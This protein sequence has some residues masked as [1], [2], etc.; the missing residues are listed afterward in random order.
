MPKVSICIPAYENPEGIKRLLRSIAGQ[1]YTDCEVILSDDSA[2]DAVERAVTEMAGAFHVSFAGGRIPLRYLRNAA[3]HGAVA[4]WNA[5]V[6][7]AQGEYVKLMHHDDW[8]TGADSLGALAALLDAH[9]DCDLAFCGTRQVPLGQQEQRER[10]AAE[11]GVSGQKQERK[12]QK[13]AANSASGPEQAAP[14]N[15]AEQLTAAGTAR[16]TGEE[17]L[18]LIRRDWRNLF[19]GNTIGAPS[20]VIVRKNLL[21][22]CAIRYDERLTWL[23]DGDYYMQILR[24]NPRFASTREPLVSIGLS[25]SQLTER[26]IDDEALVRGETVYLYRKYRLHDA[27]DPKRRAGSNQT[28]RNTD[29][30][31][32]A[33]RGAPAGQK[34]AAEQVDAFRRQ[35][36]WREKLLTVLAGTHTKTTEIPGDLGISAAEWRQA[37][38]AER[39]RE[40]ERLLGTVRYLT[41]RVQDKLERP[42]AILFLI[43]LWIEIAIVVIDKSDFLNPWEGQ[44][45]RITFLLFA[46]RMIGAWRLPAGRTG[47]E[48]GGGQMGDGVSALPPPTGR[49]FLWLAAFLVLGVVSWRLS[50]RNEL[51]RMTVFVAACRTMPVRRVMRFALWGTAAGCALLALLSVT[52]VYGVLSLTQDFGRGME[53]RYALGLGHPNALHCMALMLTVFGMYLYEKR[54]TWPGYAGLFLGNLLLYRFT[55]SNTGFAL[56][57]AAIAAFALFYASDRRAGQANR[58]GGP[59]QSAAEKRAAPVR[60]TSERQEKHSGGA[61]TCLRRAGMLYVAGE[62]LVAACILLSV[63]AAIFGYDVPVFARLDGALNG[64]IASLWDST[65]H[66][67]T[68]STWSLFSERRN[69]NFFDMGFV[70]LI[71]WYGVIPAAAMLGVLFALLRAVRRKRDAAALIM[72]V[73]Y[74]V[75]TVVEAHLVSEYILRNY[76]LLLTALYAPVIFGGNYESKS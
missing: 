67:G 58:S 22:R 28:F 63:L 32:E 4:N 57:A 37:Q 26:C 14:D 71:Y 10:E 52:G 73:V 17:D 76:L 8:F 34:S 45:F 53:T 24:E 18:E 11:G 29:S 41:G 33:A 70:R 47:T 44:L 40:R 46:C 30:K 16:F 9:T 1:H 12:E 62:I 2:S 36:A 68:L 48:S 59:K 66:D 65:F 74:S 39:R 64:R 35:S 13:A 3:P 61:F 42:T 19:L 15:T 56:T 75:Y 23:V 31:E 72:I 49:E 51:L 60:S 55:R 69:D 5:A 27:E 20:A 21:D 38:R 43:A 25:S 6:A 50:G 54:M 7:M